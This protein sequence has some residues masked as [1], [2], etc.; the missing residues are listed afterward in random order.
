VKTIGDWLAVKLHEHGMASSHLAFKMGIASS[1]VNAWKDGTTIPKAYHIR[2]M[3][4]ILGRHR[5]GNAQERLRFVAIEQKAG[6]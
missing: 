6:A 1:V 2:D 5:D 4:R 3:V